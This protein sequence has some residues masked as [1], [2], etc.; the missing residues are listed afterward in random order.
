MP[1][2]VEVLKMAETQAK[3]SAIGR[4]G[5]GHS[6]TIRGRLSKLRQRAMRHVVIV[7]DSNQ[8]NDA[9]ILALSEAGYVCQ[10]FAGYSSFFKELETLWCDVVVMILATPDQTGLYYLYKLKRLRPHLPVVVMSGNA[11]IP[12]AVQAMKSGAADF[13]DTRF[14][15]CEGIL[16]RIATACD[17]SE[18]HL[19]R[20][21][22]DLTSTEK[23][24]LKQI[25]MGKTN[26]EI[27]ERLGLS[28]RTVED[29]RS[30]I[31][32]KFGV[33]DIPALVKQCAARGILR[34]QALAPAW[35]PQFAPA[36]DS[37]Q[38]HPAEP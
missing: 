23:V 28:V 38:N 13:I 33:H 27:A 24:I 29:H 22:H 21:P 9:L 26:S 14:A 18:V 2:Q 12:L 19:E 31:T 17:Q 7:D 16:A 1:P 10:R 36:Q 15:D 37:V 25:L 35:R 32:T 6:A 4:T 5:S 30:H 3:S 20:M 11:D 34:I 8:E